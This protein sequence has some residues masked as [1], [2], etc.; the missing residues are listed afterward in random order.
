MLIVCFEFN[1]NKMYFDIDVLATLFFQ[2]SLIIYSL[3]K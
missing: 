2:Y 3:L 1:Q